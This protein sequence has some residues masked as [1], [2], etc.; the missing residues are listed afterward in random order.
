M[1]AYKMQNLGEMGHPDLGVLST[2]FNESPEEVK[3]IYDGI[4]AKRLADFPSIGNDLLEKQAYSATISVLHRKRHSKV[5][6]FEGMFLSCN[7]KI[8]DYDKRE[9]NR[10]CREVARIGADQ[11]QKAGLLNARGEPIY[12]PTAKFN[13]GKPIQNRA[14]FEIGGIVLEKTDEGKMATKPF[15]M[16]VDSVGLLPEVILNQPVCFKA[17]VGRASNDDVYTLNDTP[18]TFFEYPVREN[19]NPNI[20]MDTAA[21]IYPGRPVAEILSLVKIEKTK[22]ADG[23]EE[24]VPNV[25]KRRYLFKDLILTGVYKSRLD[26]STTLEFTHPALLKWTIYVTMEFVKTATEPVRDYTAN[27]LAQMYKI[28][29]ANKEIHL[30]GFGVWQDSA[31]R[32]KVPMGE[33]K[34]ENVKM[35]FE[36]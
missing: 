28:D 21:A 17:E 7:G 5:R 13:A 1:E 16:F 26:N 24:S 30:N 23:T 3:R 10:I 12:G 29:E 36:L 8:K 22:L 4:I 32:P 11:A 33:L 6:V 2:A 35:K 15:R 19:V 18:E 31:I 20:A 27:V 34:P 14:Y 9:Y 25:D